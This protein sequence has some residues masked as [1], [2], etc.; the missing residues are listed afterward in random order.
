MCSSAIFE[1]SFSYDK[2]IW[3]AATD[4]MHFYIIMLF[5]LT[6]ILQLINFTASYFFSLLINAVI[7]LLNCLVFSTFTYIFFLLDAIF[8]TPHYLDLYSDTALKVS[9]SL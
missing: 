1:T 4:Y 8:F 9:R 5:P 3:I 7:L 6:A 2:D